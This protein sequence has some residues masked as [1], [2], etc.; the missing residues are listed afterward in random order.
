MHREVKWFV[1]VTQLGRGWGDGVWDSDPQD[2]II[3]SVILILMAQLSLCVHSPV[4]KPGRWAPKL[5]HPL[6]R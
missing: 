3:E 5:R 6:V 4:R 1:Q 2:T